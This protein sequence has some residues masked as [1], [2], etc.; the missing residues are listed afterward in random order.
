[1]PLG[2]AWTEL[3]ASQDRATCFCKELHER[4]FA[5]IDLGQEMQ[6]RVAALRMMAEEFFAM[7]TNAKRAACVASN[8]DEAHVGME[9]VGYRASPEHLSEFLETFLRCNISDE[10]ADGDGSHADG[11]GSRALPA[12]TPPEFAVGIGALHGRLVAVAHYLLEQL[13]AYLRLP[14]AALFEPVMPQPNDTASSSLLRI[15]RYDGCGEPIAA[16]EEP[17]V[18]FPEHADNTLAA[19]LKEKELHSSRKRSNSIRSTAFSCAAVASL[20]SRSSCAS[21]S[22]A[23]KT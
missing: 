2:Y 6:E 13:A 8:D 4:G 10:H 18:A 19:G 9:G 22:S 16:D 20:V 12:V 15:C 21:W 11:D 23:S 5:V 3:T 14:E 17:A 1:M 7:T